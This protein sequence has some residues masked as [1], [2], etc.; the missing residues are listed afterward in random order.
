[1]RQHPQLISSQLHP[2]SLLLTRI[3]YPSSL[4]YLPS[5]SHT[6]Q[7]VV[8]LYL[9][10]ILPFFNYD[11][12]DFHASPVPSDEQLLVDVTRNFYE[13]GVLGRARLKSGK[14]TGGQDLPFH[15]AAV[16]SMR[17]ALDRDWDRLDAGADV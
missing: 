17:V 5:Y 8:H 1:M 9:L 4:S 2:P 11:H 12:P 10:A 3:H 14:E 7:N 16:D 15:L 6:L 13:L